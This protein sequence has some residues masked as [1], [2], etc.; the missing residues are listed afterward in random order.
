MVFG[1]ISLTET[2]PEVII[3]SSIGLFLTAVTGKFLMSSTSF[4]LSAFVMR[5][6]FFRG[7]IPES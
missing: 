3:A 2:P 1:E 6:T 5:L 7:S 4:I